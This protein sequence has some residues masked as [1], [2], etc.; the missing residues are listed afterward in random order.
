ML[1]RGY[2]VNDILEADL[3]KDREVKGLIK[4]INHLFYQIDQDVKEFLPE[5]MLSGYEGGVD[6]AYKELSRRGLVSP[7]DYKVDSSTLTNNVHVEAIERLTR[8]LMGDMNAAIRTAHENSIDGIW[9]TLD[10]F[11]ETIQR[12]VFFGSTRKEM[13]KL[14]AKDFE[15]KGLTAFIT[16]DNRRLPLEFYSEM[17]V[18]T[19]L[20]IANIEGAANRYHEMGFDLVKVS[21]SYPTCHYCYNFRDKV[22]SLTGNDKRFPSAKDNL[23]PYHPNC[24]CSISVWN[25]DRFS[26]KEIQKEIDKVKNFDPAKETRSKKQIKDYEDDQRRKRRRNREKKQYESMRAVL[27]DDAPKTLGA[28]RRMK[29]SNSDNYQRLM[30]D[31]KDDLKYMRKLK[32][33]EENKHKH[34]RELEKIEKIR[35]YYTNKP[36]SERIDNLPGR[37]H[38]VV[39]EAERKRINNDIEVASLYDQDGMHYRTIT[40]GKNYVDVTEITHERNQTTGRVFTHN[41]PQATSFSPADISILLEYKPAEMRAI[42]RTGTL[43]RARAEGTKK[44]REEALKYLNSKKFENHLKEIA[45]LAEKYKTGEITEHQFQYEGWHEVWQSAKD[46][47]KIR[48]ERILPHEKRE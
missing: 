34:E 20:K 40:G 24:Q 14:V 7:K 30:K 47:L 4:R 9:Q 21:G 33:Q 31:Y 11:K 1:L 44:E 16:K 5:H 6:E 15:E 10:E 42:D 43:Y 48:Y 19:N 2:I 26:D 39:T 3:T 32:E 45:P 27:G 38:E 29:K 37:V 17:T 22:F 46:A 41:H 18:R 36:M 35:E 23:P 13:S 25:E 12:G 28:F 8:D